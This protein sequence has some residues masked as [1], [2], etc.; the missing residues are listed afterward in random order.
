MHAVQAAAQVGGAGA[1]PRRGAIDLQYRGADQPAHVAQAECQVRGA[2]AAPV[3]ARQGQRLERR[4]QLG[5][6]AEHAHVVQ[7]DPARL[8]QQHAAGVQRGRRLHQ[9]AGHGFLAQF[10]AAIGAGRVHP[11]GRGPRHHPEGS[12]QPLR[13]GHALGHPLHRLGAVYLAVLDQPTD[14]RQR[15]QQQQHQGAD[16]E[17]PQ[18]QPE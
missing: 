7:A 13:P 3:H 18:Q 9:V 12:G 16:G 4:L 17:E 11:P 8:R 14:H 6:P 10:Q 5:L 2:V 1:Q 15:H